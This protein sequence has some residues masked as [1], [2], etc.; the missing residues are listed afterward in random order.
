MAIRNQK[1]F[2]QS[3]PAD[4]S[5][6][7]AWDFLM[8]YGAFGYNNKI[9]PMDLD[10]CIER[11]GRFLIFETKGKGVPIPKGQQ[12]TL[13]A[14]LDNGSFTLFIIKMELIEGEKSIDVITHFSYMF[15]ND[16]EMT[17]VNLEG[18]SNVERLK[19]IAKHAKIWFNDADR[20]GNL[21]KKKQLL[22]EPEIQFKEVIVE[23]EVYINIFT[24]IK[25]MFSKKL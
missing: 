25:R 11:N 22:I 12:L 8:K 15:P 6:L 4:Y 14:L 1:L 20:M 10:A 7:F 9:Q 21:T 18:L 23:K 19:L 17:H 24:L 13:N 16:K 2:D 5:G 3:L